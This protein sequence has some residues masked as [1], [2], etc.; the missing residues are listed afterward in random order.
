[1]KKHKG[2]SSKSILGFVILGMLL[3]V[4]LWLPQSVAA[5]KS[6]FTVKD[7]EDIAVDMVYCMMNDPSSSDLIVLDVRYQSEYALNHLYN[8]LLMPFDELSERIGEL[9]EYKDYT[10]IVYCRSGTRSSEASEILVEHGFAKVFNM[11]GGILAWIDKGYRFYC[12]SHHAT[13]SIDY[14]DVQIHVEP[15]VPYPPN[16]PYCTQSVPTDTTPTEGVITTTLLW[17]FE[18]NE[19]DINRT[20]GLILTEFMGEDTSFEF[21]Q[22][23][24]LVKSGDYTIAISSMLIPSDSETYSSSFTSI[25]YVPVDEHEI[26]SLEIVEFNSSATLSQ[27]YAAFGKVAD[28]IG[29]VYKTSGDEDLSVVGERYHVINKESKYLSKLVR[30]QIPEYN[31]LTE[32]IR[33]TIYDGFW[34]CF[35]CEL[36]CN[37]AVLAGCAA[38]C[39]VYP[40]FCIVCI[41][42]LEYVEVLH[43]SCAIACDMLGCSSWIW[44]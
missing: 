32:V 40:A 33:G 8:T 20:A 38:A 41:L 6:S 19:T 24:Y 3:I 35:F 30:K 11:L 21:Y 42:V 23:I 9:E 12:A 18:E 44:F 25:V 28:N 43:V 15:I 26:T 2:K 4:L 17:R 16:C 7:Y 10:I 5:E 27:Q 14:E 34:E 22:L 37:L 13:V 29:K 36:G 1:M 31:R 39:F